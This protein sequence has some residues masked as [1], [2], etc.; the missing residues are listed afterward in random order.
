MRWI[1]L[2]AVAVIATLCGCGDEAG[3]DGIAARLNECGRC[4][5]VQCDDGTWRVLWHV[6]ED[7]CR[8]QA[9]D[10]CEGSISNGQCP[11]T[12]P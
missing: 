9:R 7:D 4:E 6:C 1:R 3:D 11:P 10:E 5:G 8:C 12:W 2:L